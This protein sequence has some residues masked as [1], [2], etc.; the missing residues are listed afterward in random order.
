MIDLNTLRP[1]VRMALEVCD[2]DLPETWHSQTTQWGVIRAEL[3][4]LNGGLNAERLGHETYIAKYTAMRERAERAEAELAVIRERLEGAPQADV[5]EV[6]IGVR[7]GKILETMP[8]K[9]IGKRVR[10]VVEDSD[11]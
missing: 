5:K 1:E 4:R 10:L 2:R 9:W 3:L 7:Y 11:G 6:H 8:A